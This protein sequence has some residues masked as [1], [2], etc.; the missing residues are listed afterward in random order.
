M[1]G[2]KELGGGAALAQD[3]PGSQLPSFLLPHPPRHWHTGLCLPIPTSSPLHPPAAQCRPTPSTWGGNWPNKVIYSGMLE[4]FSVFQISS[5]TLFFCPPPP[6]LF[7]F[8]GGPPGRA[9]LNLQEDP[10]MLPVI[11]T[12]RDCSGILSQPLPGHFC[13]H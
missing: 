9:M 6:S 4:I 5:C 3:P 2:G 10:L 13:E 7:G 12:P 1:Q 11:P 8:K